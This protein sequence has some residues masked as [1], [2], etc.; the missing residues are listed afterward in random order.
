MHVFSFRIRSMYNYCQLSMR[1][2]FKVDPLRTKLGTEQLT[3]EKSDRLAQM[4]RLIEYSLC[5]TDY[6]STNICRFI[7]KFFT[8]FGVR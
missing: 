3:N 8:Q 6:V 7:L 4:C 5:T 1:S 2:L